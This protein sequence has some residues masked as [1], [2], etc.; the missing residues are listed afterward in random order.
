M[1]RE[2]LEI[3]DPEFKVWPFTDVTAMPKVTAAAIILMLSS[4]L[5]PPDD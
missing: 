3:E 5:H 1:V 2:Q 4:A